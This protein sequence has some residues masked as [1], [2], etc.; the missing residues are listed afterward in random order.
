[1]LNKGYNELCDVWSAGVIFYILLTG[2]PPFD[3]DTDEEIIKQ[4]KIGTIKYSD[5]IWDG[6]SQDCIDLLQNKMLVYNDR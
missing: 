2:I 5:P 3:G 1:M 4:V 6:F